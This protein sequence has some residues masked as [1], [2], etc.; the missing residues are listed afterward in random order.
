MK[1]LAITCKLFV[2]MVLLCCGQVELSAGDS[3][4][5]II[6]VDDIMSRNETILPRSIVP[7]EEAVEKRGGVIT[8]AVIPHRLIEPANEDGRLNTELRNSAAAGHEINL[9]GFNHICT[10]CGQSS[11]EMYCTRDNFHFDYNHQ[12]Q[13]IRDGLQIIA[14]SVGVEVYSFV[15]PGHHADQTTY[16]VLLDNDLPRISTTG[17]FG[18]IYEDLFNLP[19]HNEFTWT[20]YTHNYTDRLNG[21][22]N[23][24][25]TRGEPDGYYCILLHDPFIRAGYNDGIVIDWVGELLDSLN[26]RYGDR[27]RYKTLT[28]ASHIFADKITTVRREYP[29]L[30]NSIKLYQNF[31][32]PFNP[33]TT[34]RFTLPERQYLVLTVYNSLGQEV[35][36]LID[37]E[38]EPGHH[39][40]RFYA[41]HLSSGVYI[42]RLQAGEY[43]E[44]KKLLLLK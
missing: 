11:H 3:L 9:H 25:K 42:Y 7:F 30:A 34:I 21:A 1:Y 6:R 37:Q 33:S 26:E 43:V 29:E 44:S 24:I 5:F 40:I 23:D 16:Q 17:K 38:L 20:L 36:K 27:I 4:L 31:P 18:W 13:L 19:P 22:L 14:D 12:D 41:S 35:T 28:D 2:S 39:E 8:W 15:P 10:R 32:N